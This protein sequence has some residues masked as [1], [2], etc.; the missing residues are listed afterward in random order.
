MTAVDRIFFAHGLSVFDVQELPTHD[1]SLRVFAQR[2]GTGEQARSPRVAQL[3][4]REAQAG[5]LRANHYA[6]FQ[7]RAERDELVKRHGY[8]ILDRHE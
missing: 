7:A 8:K 1:G 3:L 5:M 2:S 4:E 6:G